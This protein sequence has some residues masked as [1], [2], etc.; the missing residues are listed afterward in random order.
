MTNFIHY[1]YNIIKKSLKSHSKAGL[2]R[3]WDIAEGSRVAVAATNCF[4]PLRLETDNAGNL[5][6]A[7]TLYLY[8][9]CSL[10]IPPTPP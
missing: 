3:Q 10:H 1:H 2:G 4:R 8:I 6:G 9:S 5:P 7:G